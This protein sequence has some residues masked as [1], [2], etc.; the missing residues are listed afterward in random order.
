MYSRNEKQLRI[1]GMVGMQANFKKKEF[2]IINHR[3]KERG[4]RGGTEGEPRMTDPHWR[5]VLGRVM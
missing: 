1:D 2:E 5:R 4:R 3:E